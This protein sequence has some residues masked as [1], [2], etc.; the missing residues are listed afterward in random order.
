[1]YATFYTSFV[2]LDQLCF[3]L[4]FPLRVFNSK[5]QSTRAMAGL[6]FKLCL[7]I[8]MPYLQYVS[9][10]VGLFVIQVSGPFMFVF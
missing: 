7:L 10:Y 8:R 5:H 2:Y 3:S 6:G 1:M 9:V 4:Y